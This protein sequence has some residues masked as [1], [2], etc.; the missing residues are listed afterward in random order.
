MT[1]PVVAPVPQAE[2]P[3]IRPAPDAPRRSEA[4][5]QDLWTAK[6]EARLAAEPLVHADM[7]ALALFAN[8]CAEV[9]NE[10]AQVAQTSKEAAGVSAFS[11][12]EAAS[13]AEEAAQRLA[14]LDALWLGPLAADPATGRNGVALVAGNAY[15]NTTTGYLRAYNGAAWVQ[16][17]SAVAGVTSIAGLVGAITAPD[18]AVA[19]L[20]QSHATALCF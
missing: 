19:T 15:V 20:A 9:T 10:G 3:Q 11:A 2:V 18:L 13:A 14:V 5:D 6:A 7:N 12:A 1:D 8:R 17:V 4:L 16:G